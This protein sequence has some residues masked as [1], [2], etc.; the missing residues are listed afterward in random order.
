VQPFLKKNIHRNNFFFKS[1]ISVKTSQKM[2]STC[3]A[4][5]KVHNNIFVIAKNILG[6]SLMKKEKEKRNDG[7]V[8][9]PIAKKVPSFF[10][11][12]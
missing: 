3:R 12:I 9:R 7:S 10:P 4:N 2:I 1:L 6:L 8:P 5:V 11:S